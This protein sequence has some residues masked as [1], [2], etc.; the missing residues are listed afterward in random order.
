MLSQAPSL[1][2]IL[3][4]IQAKKAED[5]LS[6]EQKFQ[7]EQQ[8]I[9]A[10][11]ITLDV[12]KEKAVQEITDLTA[13]AR[14][15]HALLK[16][17]LED[18]EDPTASLD[19]IRKVLSLDGDMLALFLNAGA[20]LTAYQVDHIEAFNLLITKL[21]YSQLGN[22]DDASDYTLQEALCWHPADTKAQQIMGK[23]AET[24]LMRDVFESEKDLSWLASLLLICPRLVNLKNP[25]RDNVTIAMK[26]ARSPDWGLLNSLRQ[27]DIEWDF[28]DNLGFNLFDHAFQSANREL[29]IQIPG[30]KDVDPFQWAALQGEIALCKNLIKQGNVLEKNQ[31][32]VILAAA[33][34]GNIE[35]MKILQAMGWD[36]TVQAGLALKT[37]IFYRQDSL[38]QYLLRQD[39]VYQ[40]A[41]AV[42]QDFDCSL[43]EKR[44]GWIGKPIEMCMAVMNEKISQGLGTWSTWKAERFKQD[45]QKDDIDF[46]IPEKPGSS[47][48]LFSQGLFFIKKL[49]QSKRKFSDDWKV[50]LECIKNEMEQHLKI[51]LFPGFPR[52]ATLEE[53][54]FAETGFFKEWALP[55]AALQE[56]ILPKLPDEVKSLLEE[57]QGFLELIYKK[58]GNSGI[59]KFTEPMCSFNYRF[60]L[61]YHHSTGEQV[62]VGR[63]ELR[64]EHVAEKAYPGIADL[65][66]FF[67]GCPSDSTETYQLSKRGFRA[68]MVH[69]DSEAARLV[70]GLWYQWM[71]LLG[72][73]GIKQ[74]R[75][76]PADSKTIQKALKVRKAP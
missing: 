32:V 70:F 9:Q 61:Y 49:H 10:Q 17:A 60:H 44:L 8:S 3:S 5:Q 33:R 13:G 74:D 38:V 26:L 11:K 2:S 20:L 51:P 55:V 7:A 75:Y 59:S 18:C 64:S 72:L 76:I 41:Q 6:L 31:T 19:Q 39:S 47:K 45:R 57:R 50:V 1:S 68:F 69:S 53:S 34:Y 52:F 62:R 12:E 46:S 27:K 42:Q 16:K 40:T 21:K 23:I 14:L 24:A 22:Q 43:E 30:K 25:E 4:Q 71:A 56:I 54:S 63:L 15:N 48:M 28:R 66:D 29:C 36:L 58:P 35:L 65:V 37:A 67:Y 73:N